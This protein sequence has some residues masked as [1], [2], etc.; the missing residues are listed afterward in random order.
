MW[1]TIFDSTDRRVGLISVSEITKIS[2]RLIMTKRERIQKTL[3]QKLDDLDAHLFTI[4]EH[5]KKINES[6]SHLKVLSAELRTL[7]CWSSHT[8]GFLWRLV[9]EL[10]ID[11][12]IFLHVPGDL[13]EDHPLAQGLQF[14]IVPIKR[15]GKGDPRLPPFNYSFKEVIKERQALV[16]SG[17]PFTHEYLIKAV[18]QQMGGAHEDD[19]LEQMLVDWKSVFING[20]QPYISV[21]ATNSELTLEIGERVLDSA[22]KHNGYKRHHHKHDYGNLSIV[23][24][25]RVKQYVLGRIPLFSFIFY[26]TNHIIRAYAT[27]LGIEFLILKHNS[28]VGALVSEYP[29]NLSLGQHFVFIFSYCSRTKQ[30]RTLVNGVASSTINLKDIGW[31]HASDISLE[32]NENSHTEIVEK[33]YFLCLEKLMSSE[34]SKNFTELPPNGYGLWKYR[35]ELNERGVFPE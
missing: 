4:R 32:R 14:L 13:I 15:G 1:F 16:A 29:K 5:L 9:D 27:P 21:L 8:E 33:F 26:A 11:D 31:L 20:V 25:L 17:K 2:G 7:L 34:D 30:A 3:I 35:E 28:V 19:G 23:V 24:S 12:K 6:T 22:E 10:N 18:A